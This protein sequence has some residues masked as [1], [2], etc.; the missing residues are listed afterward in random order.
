MD[1][2][3]KNVNIEDPQILNKPASNS[4][5][6]FWSMLTAY[7]GG[8]INIQYYELSILISQ[9]VDLENLVWNRE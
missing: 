2:P 3:S 7:L 6:D 9:K 5:Q 1:H 8:I 4:V